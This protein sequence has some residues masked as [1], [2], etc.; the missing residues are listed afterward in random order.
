MRELEHLLAAAG[1]R[2]EQPARLQRGQ[3][4]GAAVAAAPGRHAQI[5]F[6]DAVPLAG[7]EQRAAREPAARLPADVREPERRQH[8]GPAAAPIA[9]ERRE[10]Q[11]DDGAHHQLEIEGTAGALAHQIG[12]D[13][14]GQ[15]GLERRPGLHRGALDDV[16]DAASPKR[17]SVI[18]AGTPSLPDGPPSALVTASRR[19]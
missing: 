3:R 5:G 10:P 13:G 11:V 4:L 1:V 2:D 19:A 12:G 6:A 7:G 17:G 8:H 9:A 14:G 16:G 15:A 18:V